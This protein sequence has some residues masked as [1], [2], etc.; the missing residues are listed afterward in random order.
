MALQLSTSKNK[1]RPETKTKAND[2]KSIP[3]LAISSHIKPSTQVHN[4]LSQSLYPP[5]RCNVISQIKSSPPKII[6]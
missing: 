4:H 3:R 2:S 1:S 6:I 5:L